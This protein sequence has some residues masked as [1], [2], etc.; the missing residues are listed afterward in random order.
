MTDETIPLDACCKSCKYRT[1]LTPTMPI[2]LSPKVVDS[3]IML[4]VEDNDVCRD[5][6]RRETP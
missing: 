1:L 3:G 6:E 5:W 4:H 2:C